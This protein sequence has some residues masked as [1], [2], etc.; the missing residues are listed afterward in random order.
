MKPEKAKYSWFALQTRLRYEHF[1]T[2][3]LRNKGYD[4]FL[5]VY[6]SRRRWADRIKEVELPLFPGYVFCKFDLLNRLPILVTPGVI[7]VVG[8]GNNPIP[9]DD[10]EIASI[11]AVVRSELPRQPWPFLQLGQKVRIACGPLCG[12]EGILQNQKGNHRLVL[13]V[14]LLRRSVA[15]EVD[16]AWVSPISSKSSHTSGANVPLHAS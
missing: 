12:L 4:L 11:Q 3:H 10:A 7:Q 9:I 1:A 14:S 8:N 6:S 5:P 16:S 13:S 2:A 15:V